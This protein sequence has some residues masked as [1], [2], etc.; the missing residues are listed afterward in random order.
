MWQ[1]SWAHP[2][3]GV[4]L[5]AC[6]YDGKVIIFREQGLNQWSQAY[7]HAFHQASVNAIAWAPH[8]LGLSLAC[9]SADGTVSVLSYA[10]TS[11]CP[12]LLGWQTRPVRE[13]ADD[14]CM[15]TQRRAGA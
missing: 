5:A 11:P 7:V 2:K 4:L 10:R 9:A 13:C 3:F 6:S 1:V 14:R 15:V 12:S 8:E